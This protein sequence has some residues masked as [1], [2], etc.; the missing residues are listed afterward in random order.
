VNTDGEVAVE[1]GARDGKNDG[2][3]VPE[4]PG[5][6]TLGIETTAVIPAR[7]STSIWNVA[8]SERLFSRCSCRKLR[9]SPASMA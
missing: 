9:T 8:A 5:T 6:A 3:A 1:A 2:D 4:S 7:G